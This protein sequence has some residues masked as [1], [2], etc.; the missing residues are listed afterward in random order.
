MH[1]HYN[2]Q[3]CALWVF[4]DLKPE[5]TSSGCMT[6]MF[7]TFCLLTSTIMVL[8]SDSELPKMNAQSSDNWANLKLP[9]VNN[10]N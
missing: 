2:R 6:F 8:T 10:I 9:L 1:E 4:L 7:E 5:L 3:I